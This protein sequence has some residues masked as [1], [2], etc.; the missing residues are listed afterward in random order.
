MHQHERYFVIDTTRHNLTARQT[1]EQMLWAF[2]Q[3]RDA[4]IWVVVR[5]ADAELTKQR[6]QV[7]LS[8]E[9]RTNAD[10]V[11][12][13]DAAATRQFRLDCEQEHAKLGNGNV[14][15]RFSFNRSQRQV[16]T[17]AMLRTV[18][19]ALTDWANAESQNMQSVRNVQNG[20]VK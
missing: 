1:M 19:S 13:L 9:R 8:K 14:A 5:E 18:K 15:L 4:L 2:R 20:E 7:A 12:N 6:L 17:L 10:R 16:L 3:R 11:S